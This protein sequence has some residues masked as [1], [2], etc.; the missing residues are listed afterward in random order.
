MKEYF[1][2]FGYF[3]ITLNLKYQ[4]PTLDD[5]NL[6]IGK[7]KENHNFHDNKTIDKYFR[8]QKLIYNDKNHNNKNFRVDEKIFFLLKSFLILIFLIFYQEI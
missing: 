2:I 4:N 1:L 7:F 5:R 8:N 3:L 6:N